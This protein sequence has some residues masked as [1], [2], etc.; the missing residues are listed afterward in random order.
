VREQ[1]EALE[2][3]ADIAP[4]LVDIDA[5]AADDLA[6]EADGAALDRL[7]G[8]D[9]AQQRRLAAPGGADEADQLVLADV[10][11]MPLRTC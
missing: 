4:V 9:A 6:L 1:V 7:E 3:D 2:H 8:V 11:S 10:R 5:R